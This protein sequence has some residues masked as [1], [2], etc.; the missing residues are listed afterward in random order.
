MDAGGAVLH[1]N[2]LRRRSAC[3][4]HLDAAAHRQQVGDGARQQVAAIELGRDVHRQPHGPPGRLHPVAIGDGAEEIAAEHHEGVD[5]AGQDRL[6]G[7]DRVQ[8]GLARRLEPVLLRQLVHRHQL[9]LLGDADG[10]LALHVGVAA[11][12]RDAGAVATDVAAQQQQV[13]QHLHRLD[14]GPVLR[15]P[16]AVDPDR[17]LR[18]GIDATRRLHRRARQAGLGARSPPTRG[19]AASPATRRARACARR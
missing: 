9:R 8:P 10:A 16:H 11:H 4:V 13:H 17:R 3:S 19:C 2:R 5:L 18:G 12:R 14:A 1:R 6:A 7:L 15:Q